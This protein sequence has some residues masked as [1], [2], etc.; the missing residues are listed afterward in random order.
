MLKELSFFYSYVL[1]SG[2]NYLFYLFIYFDIRFSY[3]RRRNTTGFYLFK[4]P[5]YYFSMFYV[6]KLR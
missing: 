2:F 3:Y 6:Y 1:L 4:L 5:P